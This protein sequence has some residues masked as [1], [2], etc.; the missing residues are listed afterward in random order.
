MPPVGHAALSIGADGPYTPP[1]GR[2]DLS[3]GFDPALNRSATIAARSAPSR[4]SLRAGVVRIAVIAARSRPSRAIAA[5][6]WDP[7]LLSDVISARDSEWSPGVLA[8]VACRAR[9]RDAPQAAALAR[10]RW[11]PADPAREG[12]ALAWRDA[13]AMA[14]SVRTDWRAAELRAEPVVTGWDQAPSLNAPGADQWG[15]ARRASASTE[16]LWIGLPLATGAL[17]DQWRDGDLE[18]RDLAIRW[19]DGQ[20]IREGHVTRWRDAGYPGHWLR[21]RPPRPPSPGPGSGPVRLCIG[22][23]LPGTALHIGRRC[24]IAPTKR[25]YY[26]FNSASLVRLPDRTPLPCTALTIRADV[27]S[28]AWSLSATL[29]GRDAYA[30]VAPLAPAYLPIEVEA[31]VNGYV[32]QFLL[33]SPTHQRQFARDSVSLSGRSRSAWLAA[34]YTPATAGANAIPTSAAQAAGQ[35]L[36]N[37]GWTVDW[38]ALPDWLIPADVLRWSGTPIDRLTQ[39]ARP[40][41]GCLLSDPADDI[42]R[43]YPRYPAPPWQWSETPPD[44][45]I[46]ESVPRSLERADDR[47]PLVNGVWIGGT[48]EGLLTF[49]KIAGT[50]GAQLAELVLDPL[51]CDT[52]GLAARARAIAV[53]SASGPGSILTLETLLMPSDST[54]PPRLIQPGELVSISGEMTL[55]RSLSVTASWSAKGLEIWQTIEAE[56]REVEG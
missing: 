29:V 55:S 41:D 9:S 39:L 52:E 33:D 44:H 27:D 32:W 42:L 56:S 16:T 22:W 21:I 47:R 45:L 43:A 40:V 12:P 28:W 36:E 49:A 37:S 38:S 51:I 25:W 14:W 13:L 53:L 18:T 4:A 1:V 46:P 30:L 20:P 3:L 5:T 6:A 54:D 17:S 19:V 7:N 26:V 48:T 15:E 10:P 50:D 23:P 11:A 35:A 24:R 2:V 34:P 8:G 31:T